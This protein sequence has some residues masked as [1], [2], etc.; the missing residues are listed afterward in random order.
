LVIFILRHYI[1]KTIKDQL[2]QV[3]S[4]LNV[5]GFKRLNK[6]QITRSSAPKSKNA[7]P[8]DNRLEYFIPYLGRIFGVKRQKPGF[9]LQ[10]RISTA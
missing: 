6:G 4:C 7:H 10:F 3:T 8:Q 9:P 5:S 2:Y 1:F